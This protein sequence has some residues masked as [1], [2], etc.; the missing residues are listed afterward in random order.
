MYKSADC[1]YIGRYSLLNIRIMTDGN[2]E[3][4]GI[5]LYCVVDERVEEECFLYLTFDLCAGEPL[6]AEHAIG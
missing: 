4:C 3:K 5:V 2:V 6:Q 1:T